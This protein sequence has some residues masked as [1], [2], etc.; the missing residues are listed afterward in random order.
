M[1]EETIIKLHKSKHI[2]IQ[3]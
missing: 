2:Y 1:A 3:N